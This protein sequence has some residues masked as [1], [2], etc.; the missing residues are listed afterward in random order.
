MQSAMQAPRFT[1]KMLNRFNLKKITVKS[2]L[3]LQML[4]L[5]VMQSES[6]F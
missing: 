5:V 2:L 6:T 3:A 4:R 1:F